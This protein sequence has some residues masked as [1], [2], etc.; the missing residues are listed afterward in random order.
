[1][2][3]VLRRRNYGLLWTAQLISMIGDWA[4]FA[5]LPFFV[6]EITG[7]VLATGV[8]FMIQVLPPLLLGSVAGVFVDRWD[9]RWTMIG[10]SIF[11]GAVLLLLLGVRSAEMIWLVYIAGFLESAATQ[12]FGPA[13][14]ALLPT[15]VGEDQLL[16]ANSLDSLGENSARLIGPALGGMLLAVIGLQGVILFDIGTYLMA[17]L[18]MGL[19]RMPAVGEG[20]NPSEV[21]S[22]GNALS[23]FWSEFVSGFKLVMGK[24]ALSRI[25]LVLGVAMLGDSILTVLTVAFF[26]EVVGVGATEYG[27]VLTVRG[28]AGIL[29]GVVMGA[30]GSKFRPYHLI[31]IGLLF[32]GLALV[33]MVLFPIYA[34]ALL[35]M[36]LLSVPLMAWLISS[37]TWIQAHAPDEFRGRVFGVYGTL[38]ALLM[39]IGMGFASGLGEALGI[40]T[41]LYVGG[42]IYLL[43]GVLAILLLGAI[44][45]PQGEAAEVQPTP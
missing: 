4:M 12:F 27:V 16:T 2:L 10:S 21:A 42:A 8:M 40:S 9:R 30:I 35:I 14:N 18:L 23:V 39:L 5:A 24:P 6:Y 3:V 22:A 17:A 43:S 26:Q 36:I 13:N 37:Q 45:M 1:M 25:F 31:S 34:I 29:G 41:T 44:R 32:T 28:V 19:I 15:L 11:R 20:A 38:S 33:A 7:S